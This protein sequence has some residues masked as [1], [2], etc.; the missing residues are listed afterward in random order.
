MRIGQIVRQ[1]KVYIIFAGPGRSNTWDVLHA[2]P[3]LILQTLAPLAESR[4]PEICGRER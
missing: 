3:I 2:F 1:I 4:R